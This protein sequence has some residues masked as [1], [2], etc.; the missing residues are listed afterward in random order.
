[1]SRSESQDQESSSPIVKFP[2]VLEAEL[3]AINI[4]RERVQRPEDY[5][6]PSDAQAEAP[7]EERAQLMNLVGLSLSGGGVRSA[8]VSLG[9][10]QGLHR[11]GLLR[12]V[13]YL[14][15]VSGGGYAAS[16]LSSL[17][18]D[19]DTSDDSYTKRKLSGRIGKEQKTDSKLERRL[20][21]A[22][23]SKREK[24]QPQKIKDLIRSGDFLLKRA[25]IGINRTFF[26][27]L[28]IWTLVISGLIAATSLAAYLYR[29]LDSVSCRQFLQVLGIND[30]LTLDLFPPFVMLLIY[31]LIW[32]ITYWRWGANAWQVGGNQKSPVA[33]WW[34]IATL[35]VF[36]VSLATLMG[37]RE[38][39]T[40][41]AMV[42]LIGAEPSAW[43]KRGI[44]SL[45]SWI[46]PLV[47]TGLFPWFFPKQLFMSGGPAQ[48]GMK[49]WIFRV[50]GFALLGG[51]PF[52]FVVYFATEGIGGNQSRVD[53][54]LRLPQ[55]KGWEKQPFA[56][57][58]SSLREQVAI[59]RE[60]DRVVNEENFK[61]FLNNVFNNIVFYFKKHTDVQT[62]LLSR[63]LQFSEPLIEQTEHAAITRELLKEDG[64]RQSSREE[65]TLWRTIPK[66]IEF[67]VGKKHI[68]SST[69]YS[70]G[71]LWDAVN[72]KTGGVKPGDRYDEKPE[73]MFLELCELYSKTARYELIKD[74]TLDRIVP[75]DEW[76]W[77]SVRLTLLARWYYLIEYSLGC[78]FG[79]D[80]LDQY[81]FAIIS[82]QHQDIH[83]VKE[84]IV[85]RMN[86]LLLRP[87][88]HK[89]FSTFDSQRTDDDEKPSEL[90]PP[91][92][93]DFDSSDAE[94]G[95]KGWRT[96]VRDS[97][98]KAKALSLI[99]GKKDGVRCEKNTQ[100]NGGDHDTPWLIELR[101]RWSLIPFN[102]DEELSNSR[103]TISNSRIRE[104]QWDYP[105]EMYVGH[106]KNI[107]KDKPSN[108][109]SVCEINLTDVTR[110][111]GVNTLLGMQSD[112][113]YV[114]KPWGLVKNNPLINLK[115][116]TEESKTPKEAETKNEDLWELL[117]SNTW[118]ELPWRPSIPT[119]VR[120]LHR[121]FQEK[122]T[123]NSYRMRS[124][125]EA[126]RHLLSAYFEGMIERNDAVPFSYMVLESDQAA[127][128]GWFCWSFGIFI[129]IAILF[130]LNF[131]SWHGF[132]TYRI[133]ET[134][135]NSAAGVGAE[136][137]LAQ[138]R[139]TDAG[140][141]YH[142]INGS[143][144]STTSQQ[145]GPENFLLSQ[146]F[147]GSELTGYRRVSDL[148]ERSYNLASA[149]AISGG[150]VSPLNQ[151]N[152][153]QMVLLFLCNFRLG[154][155]IDNPGFQ[156]RR[157]RILEWLGRNW[158]FSPARFL[159]SRYCQS[160][161]DQRYCFVTDGGLTENL[162]IQSLIRRRCQ[163]I[164]AVDAGQD[165]RYQFQDLGKL[166][167]W[168]QVDEG[169]EITWMPVPEELKERAK[170]AKLQ[171]EGLSPVMASSRSDSFGAGN[172]SRSNWLSDLIQSSDPF[173]RA[174]N[175]DA[176]QHFLVGRIQ[177]PVID[178][179]KSNS[180]NEN[181]FGYLVYMKST[182]CPEDPVELVT[183]QQAN[184][185]FPHEPTVELDFTPE[186]FETYRHL[187]ETTV[188]ATLKALKVPSQDGK[189]VPGDLFRA[190]D[191]YY[192]NPENTGP[193]LFLTVITR[194]DIPF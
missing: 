57:L 188:E 151:N 24:K 144:E 27:I 111:M 103:N 94:K 69:A 131:T 4:R 72:Q 13:D 187:G 92:G 77:P 21:E 112:S 55:I 79:L 166:L 31:L 87:D 115:P 53:H 185:L 54:R 47:A 62:I 192:N 84:R 145:R 18:L 70:M 28:F 181:S 71:R 138:L 167:R 36:M 17:A 97:Y 180:E 110:I 130:D 78:A 22:L 178:S 117:R 142:L 152:P 158:M 7:A 174:N 155:W 40:Y 171:P 189:I 38:N 113:F 89:F 147:A 170:T 82:K 68:N 6:P 121:D 64:S 194:P 108:L 42:G 52:L 107:K 81:N 41:D 5:I 74:T 136:I 90:Y 99:M 65:I 116:N 20:N 146:L 60:R 96:K 14:S 160:L 43:I 118:R 169:V 159:I 134:W 162:G 114:V 184:P 172:E 150:A 35:V 50:A 154:R 119:P 179:E 85:F 127:R 101:P 100:I 44:N 122:L 67:K 109:P 165:G 105:D 173:G 141:P 34:L 11:G 95:L 3:D 191:N 39:L 106:K 143:I 125:L 168:L 83:N 93:V 161:R 58:W 129:L 132:Y 148:Q 137:P 183:Y 153:L 135:I 156:P 190:V 48:S 163:V 12:L 164:F 23:G 73:E 46:V 80:A 91:V 45:S 8:V 2:E 15:S 98:L 16:Y 186:Q 193:T 75:N 182:I 124:M 175:P 32:F 29:M 56:P 157:G 140:L 25:W 76:S 66:A 61:I 149:T 9:V 123:A 177:Y 30:Q 88:F 51:V 59:D 139:T 33:R 49:Q 128:W 37:S 126:N 10:L 19:P 104:E 133:G 63:F 26:A 86:Q 120:E 176:K 1:M 102:V